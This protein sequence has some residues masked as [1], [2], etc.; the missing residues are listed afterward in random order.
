MYEFFFFER[1]CAIYTG[2]VETL[3]EMNFNRRAFDDMMD[4]NG[5]LIFP[6]IIAPT[7]PFILFAVVC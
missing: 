6:A 1:S 4:V 2:V 5:G 7:L 3:I